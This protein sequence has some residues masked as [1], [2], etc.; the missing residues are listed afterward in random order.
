VND[1]TQPT[2]TLTKNGPSLISERKQRANRENAKK[3]TGPRTARGKALSRR[4][5]IK[6]GLFARDLFP[7]FFLTTESEADFLDFSEQLYEAYDPV[8]ME[9]EWEVERIAIYKW[10]LRRL[11]RYENAEISRAALNAYLEES[12]K[13]PEYLEQR[14]LAELRQVHLDSLDAFWTAQTVCGLVKVACEQQAIPRDHVVD[15]IIRYEAATERS[16]GRALER[17]ETLQQ[18]RRGEAPPPR[19]NVHVR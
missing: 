17:L 15:K 12:R 7:I 6:H 19:L 10:K 18:R 3:S 1:N 11:W 8:G 4:N 13:H 2:P 16:L 5:A 9:E 14:R